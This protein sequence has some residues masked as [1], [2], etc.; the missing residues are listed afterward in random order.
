VRRHATWRVQ[1]ACVR[2]CMRACVF[3]SVCVYVGACVCMCVCLFMSV[4]VHVYMHSCADHKISVSMTITKLLHRQEPEL[5]DPSQCRTSQP[6][7]SISRSINSWVCGQNHHRADHRESY[8]PNDPPS[9]KPLTTT[10]P[11]IPQVAA[12]QTT[13]SC[14]EL[15]GQDASQSRPF[16]AR[17]YFRCWL[18]PTWGR[19]TVQTGNMRGMQSKPLLSRYVTLT[20][21]N[22]WETNVSGP[23]SS[24]CN[25]CT[26]CGRRPHWGGSTKPGETAFL[27]TF[28]TKSNH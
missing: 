1:C 25:S 10:F 18:T 8:L 21:H 24:S 13:A 22:G 17:I 15:S 12:L 9:T 20:N 16:P 11:P 14:C 5:R 3:V 2:V 4:R 27:S 19:A 6:D 26:G 28:L 7:S 23:D